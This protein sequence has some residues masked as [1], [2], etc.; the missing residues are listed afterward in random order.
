L[1]EPLR[2]AV[3]TT[4]RQDYGVLRST[5]LLLRRDPRFELLLWVGGMHLSPAFGSTVARIEADGLA[6]DQRLDFL[7]STPDMA[8]EAS[9]AL[10]LVARAL[11][12]RRPHALMLLGDRYET[13]AAGFAAALAGIPIAHLHGGEETEGAIDNALRH[14]LT[15]LSHLH[16]VSHELHARR[17]LQ[18]GEAAHGVVVV[19]AAGLDNLQRDDLPDRRALE[20]QLGCA[21]PAP[22][23]LVTLHPA[24]LGG[25]P[26]AEAE[27][28]SS[29]MERVAATYVITQ[30]NADAGG[31][32]IRE[33]WKRWSAGRARTVLAD[34]L[35]ETRY[36]GLLRTADA[37]AGNSS[38]GLLEAPAAGLPV[39][40]VGDRQRGRLRSAHVTDVPA[41]AAAIAAALRQALAPETRARLRT[42]AGI[43]PEGPAAP[44]IVEALAG[45]RP[46]RPAR[47]RF[48]DLSWKEAP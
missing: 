22:L 46:P 12:A 24:T 19:G 29:A 25:A 37:V 28:L 6:I 3:L 15:K 39:I 23:V 30:P 20:A 2:L 34:A 26:L 35:G 42:V 47:K 17:V 40:N 8:V 43:Y 9:S 31:A 36:F 33:H 48:V 45:W 5:L 21:L 1:P 14:A 44:R 11:E 10:S 7:A 27:A 38:S 32:A 18:M 13:L 41:D 16:L 4:G